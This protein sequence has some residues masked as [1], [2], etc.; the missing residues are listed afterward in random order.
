MKNGTTIGHPREFCM[1]SEYCNTSIRFRCSDDQTIRDQPSYC[2]IFECGTTSYVNNSRTLRRNST[3]RKAS[4]QL[5]WEWASKES[6]LEA[7]AYDVVRVFKAH[8]TIMMDECYIRFQL[9]MLRR[10]KG[11]YSYASGR[12]KVAETGHGWCRICCDV[13]FDNLAFVDRF[14]NRLEHHRVYTKQKSRTFE[15]W[16]QHKTS[17]R[18]LI[19]T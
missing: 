15:T 12:A 4:Y 11:T 2:Y 13:H 18:H 17:R 10:K 19:S 6:P 5:C 1:G 7:M 8:T 3:S 9:V 16:K 14:S